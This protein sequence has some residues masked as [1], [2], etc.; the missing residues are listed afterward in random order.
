MLQGYQFW[1]QTDS[2]GRFLIPNVRVGI[3]NFFAWVPGFIGDYKSAAA[4]N[5]VAGT[6]LHLHCQ[7]VISKTSIPHHIMSTSLNVTPFKY[8]KANKHW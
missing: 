1:I 8:R 6:D 3:Y 5:I 7:N 2:E 4:V